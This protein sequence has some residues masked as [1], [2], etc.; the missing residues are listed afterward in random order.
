MTWTA[1]HRRARRRRRRAYRVQSG[2]FGGWFAGL[3]IAAAFAPR[4]AP[5][6]SR[7]RQAAA[8]R[9]NARRDVGRC[10]VR[11]LSSPFVSFTV[12]KLRYTF[13]NVHVS[14]AKR[15]V[16]GHTPIDPHVTGFL[17]S[18]DRLLCADVIRHHV[19]DRRPF[20]AFVDAGPAGHDVVLAPDRAAGRCAA[21][22]RSE[23]RLPI[24]LADVDGVGQRRRRAPCRRPAGSRDRG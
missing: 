21:A 2:T 6:R 11:M 12:R 8:P 22:C 18:D 20:G 17:R 19:P 7:H 15:S 9:R 14:A 16:L 5:A 10:A 24:G 23:M 3:P 1:C 4:T 13:L